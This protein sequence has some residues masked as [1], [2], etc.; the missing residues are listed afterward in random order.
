MATSAASISSSGSTPTNSISLP[1]PVASDAASV[2]GPS[3]RAWRDAASAMTAI[4]PSAAA[5][6]R[7]A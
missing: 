3:A 1:P 7:A 6:Y 2:A 5:A 4:A